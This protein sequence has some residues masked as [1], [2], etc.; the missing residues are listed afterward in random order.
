VQFL[1]VLGVALYRGI[2]QN[3]SDRL[4]IAVFRQTGR[5]FLSNLMKASPILNNVNGNAVPTNGI[6]PV[7]LLCQESQ[8]VFWKD[9]IETAKLPSDQVLVQAG[10]VSKICDESDLTLLNNDEDSHQQLLDEADMIVCESWLPRERARLVVTTGGA[11]LFYPRSVG[12][13]KADMMAIYPKN[14]TADG[15]ETDINCLHPSARIKLTLAVDSSRD[16][17][18]WKEWT[19]SLQSA[20]EETQAHTFWRSLVRSRRNSI[21]FTIKVVDGAV[22]SSVENN[23]T[24]HRMDPS[25]LDNVFG[26]MSLSLQNHIEIVMYLPAHGS[27][28]FGGGK[29]DAVPTL[30]AIQGSRLVRILASSSMEDSVAVIRNM[31]AND[32]IADATDWITR[33]CMG[34][35]MNVDVKI[36]E[37]SLDGSLP[38]WYTKLWWHRS[39]FTQYS[40]A[41]YMAQRQ[42]TLWN[43]LSYRVPLTKEIV[44]EFNNNVL[45]SLEEIPKLLAGELWAEA[46]ASLE[47]SLDLLEKWES[48]DTY[49]PPLD[50]PP[51]QYA[52]IF[53]PLVV[54]LLLPLLVGLIREFRR[55]RELKQK[56]IDAQEK[57]D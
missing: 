46:L 35:P 40:K 32:A 9:I 42:A 47:A 16:R 52:A 53:A 22:Q 6:L 1:V 57:R 38:R 19:S 37:D 15:D 41:V 29:V 31:L 50:F 43:E 45:K 17:N 51:E 24:V 20:L 12:R 28:H 49:M 14:A 26:K 33:Q 48:D 10:A 13:R 11:L 25:S 36:D 30:M 21:E 54:P 56:K 55:Y 18:D 2:L 4:S 34:I 39:L 5:G 7:K 44:D 27:T 8:L 23:Q 3:P